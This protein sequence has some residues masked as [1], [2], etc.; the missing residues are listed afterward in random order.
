M[1]ALKVLLAT[2]I[3]GVASVSSWPGRWNS[4]RSGEVVDW[5]R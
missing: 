2:L 1:N 3:N 4:V 5:P